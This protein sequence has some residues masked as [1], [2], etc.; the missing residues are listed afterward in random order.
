MA[1]IG[2]AHVS[3]I[4]PAPALLPDALAAA[5][6]VREFADAA[7]GALGCAQPSPMLWW[8]TGRAAA[9]CAACTAAPI[10]DGAAGNGSG[11]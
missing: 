7:C 8:S 10:T 9:N 6:G 5:G 3:T 4:A 11:A 1:T 2:C